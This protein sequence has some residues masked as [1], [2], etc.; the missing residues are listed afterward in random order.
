MVEKAVFKAAPQ[1]SATLVHCRIVIECVPTWPSFF[2][3]VL[4]FEKRGGA[5]PNYGS[6]GIA[7]IPYTRGVCTKYLV[8]VGMYTTAVYTAVVLVLV[9]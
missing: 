9:Y 4:I 2:K 6:W 3:N 8:H 1:K 5:H 7:R